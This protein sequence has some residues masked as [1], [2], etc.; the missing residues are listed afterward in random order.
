ASLLW[1][2]APFGLIEVDHP[3]MLATVERIERDL[4]VD[5]GVS[6]YR[7]DT[8]YG[9]GEWIILSASLAWYRARSG[10]LAGA[11]ICL[12]W[13]ERQRRPDGSLPEQVP[14]K[15]AHKRFLEH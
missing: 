12:D 15:L 8:Y 11:R 6:H 1:L 14:R 3:V 10:D 2:A 7:A 5:G 9:G 4:L 13:I